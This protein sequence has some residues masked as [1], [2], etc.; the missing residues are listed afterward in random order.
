MELIKQELSPQLYQL[1]LNW[2]NEHESNIEHDVFDTKAWNELV[3]YL[4][5]LEKGKRV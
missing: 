4:M 5:E 1:F 2:I 3:M